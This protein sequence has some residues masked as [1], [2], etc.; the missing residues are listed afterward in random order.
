MK[1]R[2]RHGSPRQPGPPA[3]GPAG[4][5]AGAILAAPAGKIRIS[6][7]KTRTRRPD[8]AV[9]PR[10]APCQGPRPPSP[11]ASH[12]PCPARRWAVLWRQGA[13]AAA[14]AGGGGPPD[15]NGMRDYGGQGPSGLQGLMPGRGPEAHGGKRGFGPG[16]LAGLW[17]DPFKNIQG[18]A[19]R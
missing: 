1:S 4:Q 17:L 9:A 13:A 8:S 7:R 16:P 2:C 3:G 12:P 5:G 18:R 19:E 15:C 11:P 6:T 10:P 14:G